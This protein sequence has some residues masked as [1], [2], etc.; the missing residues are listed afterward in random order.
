MNDVVL[1]MFFKMFFDMVV[2]LMNLICGE[3]GDLP[4]EVLPSP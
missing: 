4:M 2:K 1:K 3:V